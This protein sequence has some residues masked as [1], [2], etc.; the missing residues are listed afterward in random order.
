MNDPDHELEGTLRAMRWR[1]ASPEFLQRS[2]ET[3]LAGHKAA[4]SASPVDVVASNDRRT[5]PKP[6]ILGTL[7]N[8]VPRPI[9]WPLAACWLLS[10]FFRLSTPDPVPPSLR[11]SLAHLPQVDPV[12]LLAQLDEQHRI[13]AELIEQL[14]SR[15]NDPP[16]IFT[17]GRSPLP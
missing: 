10:L 6:A 2:L 7:L 12:V 4:Q 8:F 5:K 14:H 13:L 16:V 3:A 11:E 1:R 15:H 9:R 17:P